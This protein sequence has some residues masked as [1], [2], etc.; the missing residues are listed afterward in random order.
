M[1]IRVKGGAIVRLN[2]KVIVDVNQKEVTI[3]LYITLY[4]FTKCNV[5][6]DSINIILYRIQ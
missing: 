5:I 4:R 6:S 2:H 1:T 3:N